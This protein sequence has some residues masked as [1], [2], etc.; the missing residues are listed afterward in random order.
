MEEWEEVGTRGDV[1]V[2]VCNERKTEGGRKGSERMQRKTEAPG[3][4][5]DGLSSENTTAFVRD[6]ES[7]CVS[8]PPTRTPGGLVDCCVLFFFCLLLPFL[9]HCL[10]Y[11]SWGLFR[12]IGEQRKLQTRCSL[13]SSTSSLV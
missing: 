12:L 1:N 9:L 8:S 13:S 5:S 11:P 3:F 6:G 10:C 2:C 7:M 4:H